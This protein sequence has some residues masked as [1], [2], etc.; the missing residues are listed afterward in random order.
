[1]YSL[2]NT[3][4]DFY[5]TSECR[6]LCFHYQEHRF[7]IKQLKNIL[8]SNNLKFLGFFLSPEFKALYKS[9]FPQDQK[10]INLENW[11]EFEIK[12]PRAFASTPGFWV[13]N[14]NHLS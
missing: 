9:Y 4:S 6:D 13:T 5:S 2:T 12:H 7:T 10:Q 8:T 3:N 11:E 14:K 1:M